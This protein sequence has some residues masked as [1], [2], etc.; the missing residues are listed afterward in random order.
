MLSHSMV[1]YI[2]NLKLVKLEVSSKGKQEIWGCR[3]LIAQFFKENFPEKL[4]DFTA[5][6]QSAI[7][8]L[9]IIKGYIC[10]H[11]P[12]SAIVSYKL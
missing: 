9:I 2:R 10:L 1:A 11:M 4:F 8:K 3:R 5:W 12:R 6:L 7:D